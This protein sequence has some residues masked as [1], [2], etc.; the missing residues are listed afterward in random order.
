[1]EWQVHLAVELD[2]AADDELLDRLIEALAEYGAAIGGAA[3]PD[4]PGIE[5]TL[6]I[7]GPDTPRA[8]IDDG[9]GALAAALATHGRRVVGWLGAEAITWQEAERRLNQPTFPELVS[10]VEAAAIL[11]VSRQRVHQ[12]S[13]EHRQFP[14]PVARLASGSVWLRSG[15]EGF[16]RTSTRKP[17]R[18]AKAS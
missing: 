10:G 17:G 6:A 7:T 11:G 8:A 5:V 12:L 16:A 15:V 2:R 13:A 1:M 18:P 14:P 4:L 9:F 3:L